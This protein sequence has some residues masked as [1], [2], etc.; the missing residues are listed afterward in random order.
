MIVD[1]EELNP[2]SADADVW[3]FAPRLFKLSSRSLYNRAPN[4]RAMGQIVLKF[5]T[6]ATRCVLYRQL[7]N[8]VLKLR[9]L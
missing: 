1:L 7:P 8:Q 5:M 4:N 3:L 2:D 9:M 6:H